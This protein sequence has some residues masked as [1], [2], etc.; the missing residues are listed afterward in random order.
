VNELGELLKPEIVVLLV[1]ERPGLATAE[2]LSAYMAYRPKTG[3]TDANRNLI[4]NV[5]ACGVRPEDAS[6]R[7]LDLA[8]I[9]LK[10]QTSGIRIR[11]SFAVSRELDAGEL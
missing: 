2:S 10:A 1:G 9:M 6:R 8:A 11:E 4:S 3:H 5:H 7:I